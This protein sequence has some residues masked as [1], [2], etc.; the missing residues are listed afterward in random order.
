MSGSTAEATKLLERRV[1]LKVPTRRDQEVTCQLLTHVGL[2]CVVCSDLGTVVQELRLGVGVVLL[3]EEVIFDPDISLFLDSLERQP[4]WSDLP[5]ILMVKG[6]VQSPAA[7]NVLRALRNVTLMERPAPM[8]SI[9]SVVQAA[10]RARERQYQSREQ[11]FAIAAAETQARELR[12]RLQIALEASDLGTF[13]CEIP[14]EK[15]IT[16]NARCKAHFWMRPDEEINLH[17]FYEVL[18]PEDRDPVRQAIDVCVNYGAPYDIEYRTVSPSG[19]IRWVR[20]TGRTYYDTRRNPICFDGTTQDITSMRQ[21]AI[22]KQEL[23]DSERAARLEAERV[24]RMKD[25]F[26]AT[27]SHELRTPLNAIFGWTQLLKMTKNDP[28]TIEEGIDVIDRNVRIQSQLIEDLLDMSRIISGKVRLNVQRI[29]L[30]TVI[31]AAIEGLLP[32][33]NAKGIR[34]EKELHRTEGYVNGDPGRLQQVIWNL[35]TNA[36]K[37][38][39]SGGWIRLA[40]RQVNSH[41]E[42][43]VSDNGVGISSDFLP[44]LFERFSQADGSIKRKHGGLGLGLSIVK[45]LVELHGGTIRAQSPGEDLGTT[46]TICIPLVVPTTQPDEALPR[47]VSSLNLTGQGEPMTLRGVKVLVVD[48]E[49]DA[50]ELVKRFLVEY[51]AIPEIAASADEAQ[52]IFAE[53]QPDVIVSD[54]GMPGQDGYEFMRNIRQSGVRTPAVALTAFARPEDRIRS[55]QAGY[56]SHLPKPIEPV[57]L[58]AVIA[59]LSERYKNTPE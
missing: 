13:H 54:I 1:L 43:A 6:G 47:P 3:T 29:D 32:A 59:S 58:L 17:K 25:E 36:I 10:L 34:L 19:E 12:E 46:F 51:E 14:L 23:L 50:R 7:T 53:F 41:L 4:S 35:L 28:A 2:E 5:V 8:R 22:E 39:P 56:Q 9:V 42:L 30:S 45:T 49:P 27:L 40:L 11:F 52:Q 44:H 18:H 15:K 33:L 57:E 24:S 16:W 55:L 48:D 31:N 20:A 37:F 21:K 26:L 38:T